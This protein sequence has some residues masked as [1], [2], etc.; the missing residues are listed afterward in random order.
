[1]KSKKVKDVAKN[2]S[3]RAIKTGAKRNPYVLAASMLFGK[4]S[5]ADQPVEGK[6]KRKYPGGEIDFT[7]ED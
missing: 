6:G 7:G 3:K 2:V 5:K 1:M 4:T